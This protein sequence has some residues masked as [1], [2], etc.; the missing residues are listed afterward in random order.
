[1][2]CDV[3]VSAPPE[4]LTLDVGVEPTL[5]VGPALV[6]VV[7]T[8]SLSTVETGMASSAT[9]RSGCPAATFSAGDWL[10]VLD[11]GPS[12]EVVVPDV[13]LVPDV[14]V[15]PDE[16]ADELDDE[17]VELVSALAGAAMATTVPPRAASPNVN[18]AAV[19]AMRVLIM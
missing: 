19:L 16:E 8:M 7:R 18:R 3:D 12:V 11:A 14:E 13:V 6:L 5:E 4:L 15:S 1:M 2:V 17:E 9:L 10:S